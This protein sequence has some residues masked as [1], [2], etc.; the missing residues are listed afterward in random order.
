MRGK[1]KKGKGC[2]GFIAI[3]VAVLLV[4]FTVP[5]I[6]SDPVDC[7][8]C[9]EPMWYDEA[10]SEPVQSDIAGASVGL[11]AVTYMCTLYPFVYVIKQILGKVPPL[12]PAAQ[13]AEVNR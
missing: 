2:R 4:A 8:K 12:K 1:K 11:V 13:T 9:G 3:L 7:W 5:A 10:L 6:A